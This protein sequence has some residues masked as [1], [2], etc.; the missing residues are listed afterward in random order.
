M[1]VNRQ[2]ENNMKERWYMKY[3]YTATAKFIIEEEVSEDD[4]PNPQEYLDN[5]LTELI[6]DGTDNL[7]FLNIESSFETL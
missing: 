5:A 3:R 1:I 6:E 2:Y 4:F 7:K